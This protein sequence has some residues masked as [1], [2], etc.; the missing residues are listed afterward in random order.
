MILWPVHP[1]VGNEIT[2]H[3]EKKGEEDNEKADDISSC[4]AGKVYDCEIV[5]C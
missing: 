5:T 1:V 2:K 3:K 4:S